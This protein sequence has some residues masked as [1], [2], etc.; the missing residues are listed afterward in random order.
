[1]EKKVREEGGGEGGGVC[2]CNFKSLTLDSAKAFFILYMATSLHTC[3]NR[4]TLQ[5]EEWQAILGLRDMQQDG[6]HSPALTAETSL[7]QCC[8]CAGAQ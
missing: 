6:L 2:V 1:M 4:D 7:L 3:T 5:W 8:Q